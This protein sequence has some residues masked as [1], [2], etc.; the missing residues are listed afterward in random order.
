MLRTKYLMVTAFTLAATPCLAADPSFTIQQ[1]VLSYGMSDTKTTPQGGTESAD[2]ETTLTTMPNSLLL[3]ATMEK[4]AVYVYP[5]LE[6]TP[7]GVGYYV[8]PQ[9][10]V[11]ATASLASK[12]VDSESDNRKLTSSSSSIGVYATYYHSIADLA[13]EFYY[14]PSFTTEKSEEKD[15]TAGTVTSKS[16]VSGMKHL[17]S[18]YGF[19]PLAKNLLYG[20]GMDVSMGQS[21]SDEGSKDKVSSSAFVVNPAVLRLNF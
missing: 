1:G 15:K 19:Y 16:A 5:T 20:A 14:S 12:D 6:G 13:L 11:G 4:F 9:L 10:E 2:S 21:E 7:V 17:A 18:V 8:L 3:Y